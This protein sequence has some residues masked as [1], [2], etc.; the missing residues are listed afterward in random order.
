MRLR[1]QYDVQ[2]VTGGKISKNDYDALLVVQPNNLD[3]QKMDD[4]IAAIKSGIPTAIFEDP[5]PLI[6]GGLTGTY[7]PRAYTIKAV[8]V[9]QPPP[10]APEKGDL[11]KLWDLL[12]VH[13]NV[14]PKDRITAII[15]VFNEL[16]INANPKHSSILA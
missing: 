1:K 14:N 6:Q 12:G 15:K 10:P 3:N 9:G 4:L 16:R 5:L 8:V 2:E 13:F 7:D 11:N